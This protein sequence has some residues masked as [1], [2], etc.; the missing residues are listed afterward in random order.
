MNQNYDVLNEACE[1]CG[2]KTFPQDLYTDLFNHSWQMICPR[3]FDSRYSTKHNSYYDKMVVLN[4]ELLS[5]K[6]FVK[7]KGKYIVIAN[8]FPYLKDSGE[9]IT[10]E[11][12]LL[13]GEM[14]LEGF[15]S[16]KII[17]KFNIHKQEMKTCDQVL[18]AEV[19]GQ[20]AHIISITAHVTFKS[21]LEYL[22]HE[23]FM[24]MRKEL[25]NMLIH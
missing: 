3:C 6:E 13:L 9:H 14:A 23:M 16:S 15:I 1:G 19:G 20:K 2:S 7:V 21:W 10:T 24:Y 4:K 25:K 22:E 5:E 8:S 18:P 11:D 12:K 17:R